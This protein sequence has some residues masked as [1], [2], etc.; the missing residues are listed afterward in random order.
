MR[1]PTIVG[2]I[3]TKKNELVSKSKGFFENLDN[4]LVLTEQIKRNT[5]K[6]NLCT[7]ILNN[8]KLDAA[9]DSMKAATRKVG[10]GTGLQ[11]LQYVTSILG[12]GFAVF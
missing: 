2:T 12:T 9:I 7:K 11:V 10:V 8:D 6:E 4:N 3:L 5:L 1:R